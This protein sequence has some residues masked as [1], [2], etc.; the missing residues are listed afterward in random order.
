MTVLF[1]H[2]TGNP[3]SHNAALAHFE[4]GRLEAFCVPWMPA[5]IAPRALAAFGRPGAAAQRLG[6]RHFAPL[7]LAPKVQGRIGEW[8]RLALRAAGLGG[9]RLSYEANDWLMATMAR[10]ARRP[11][12]TAVHAYEDCSLRQFVEARRL[13]KACIYDMPIGYYPTWEQ[14]QVKLARTYGDWLPA[15]GLPSSR[16]VRPEQKREEMRLADLVLVPGEFVEQTVRSFH[17]DKTITRADYGV[18]LEFWTPR[19]EP[20][21]EGPL[22]FLYAGQLSLR[23]GIPYLIEA[24]KK[25]A[26]RDAELELVGLWQLADG[27]RRN[28][29][30]SVR[31]RLPLAPRELRE[32]Y[33]AADVFLFPSYFEGFAL[34]LTEA[35]ACG[36]PAIASTATIGSDIID[37]TCGSLVPPGDVDALVNA[38]RWFAAHRDRLPAMS[39]AAR[40][41]AEKM[42]WARYRK[43]VSAAV[44]PFL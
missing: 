16:Y 24:W 3:N 15:G 9:E 1:G 22:R 23:K 42:T 2:P 44:A 33:R 31:H 26:L 20:V 7:A 25:A 13:G 43:A 30:A 27:Q 19:D 14:T 29:P 38:L 34:V 17:P 4:S 10:E 5:A 12:V 8:R 40:R 37:D 11:G 35:M 36:L 32:R 18:D 21:A 6:R 39:R 41:R 28:L